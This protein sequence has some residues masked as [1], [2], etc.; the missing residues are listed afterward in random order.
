MQK[1]VLFVIVLFCFQKVRGVKRQIDGGRGPVQLG[2][3]K[4]RPVDQG[5]IKIRIRLAH[6]RAGPVRG[7][8]L[9]G[10]FCRVLD[11]VDRS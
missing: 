3:D 2:G 1:H 8:W 10:P 6:N 7:R 5:L 9:V 11:D 4:D